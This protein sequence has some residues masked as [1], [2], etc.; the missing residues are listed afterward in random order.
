MQ[1]FREKCKNGCE[2]SSNKT[3]Y[4]TNS[5]GLRKNFS[6]MRNFRENI[7]FF[8]KIRFGIALFAPF[9]FSLNTNENFVIFRETFRSLQTLSLTS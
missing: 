8:A 1:K 7:I 6:E 5:Y 9:T 2:N 4:S 3:K